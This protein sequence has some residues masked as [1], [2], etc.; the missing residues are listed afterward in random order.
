MKFPKI[1]RYINEGRLIRLRERVLV[2][3]EVNRHTIQHEEFIFANYDVTTY[4]QVSKT[5]WN[6]FDNCPTTSASELCYVWRKIVNTDPS[7]IERIKEIVS[8]KRRVIIF[9][10]YD[11]ELD[12]LKNQTYVV[13]GER[14]VIA[15]WNGHKHQPVPD[16]KFWVYLVQYSAGC[17]GWN[18]IK[19]D[20]I[21]FYSQNYS[22]KIVT[23]AKGRIDRLNTPF[24]DLYYYTFLSRAPIDNAI[25]QALRNKK[26]FNESRYVVNG[27]KKSTS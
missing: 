4:K 19:T 1:D 6:I 15:E 2:D 24:V 10:N 11:Y 12:I 26:K 17:E 5:R 25:R 9:Y 23:Q 27:Y 14:A 13:N 20:T 22:Y 3:M 7:R 18:C 8:E 21:I 16:S